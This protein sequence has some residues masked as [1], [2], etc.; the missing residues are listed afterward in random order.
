[1]TLLEEL[2]TQRDYWLVPCSR[3][4][5]DGKVDS[6]MKIKKGANDPELEMW[7][8][9]MERELWDVLGRAQ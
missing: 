9:R 6:V 1:M 7:C 8:R 5:P 4:D 3:Q 2:R